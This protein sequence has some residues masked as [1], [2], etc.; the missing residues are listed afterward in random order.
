MK[1]YYTRVLILFHTL[2]WVGNINA[3]SNP[4]DAFIDSVLVHSNDSVYIKQ[5]NNSCIQFYSE[6]QVDSAILY[7]QKAI[8][9][10]KTDNIYIARTYN[11]IANCY[12]LKGAYTIVLNNYLKALSIYEKFNYKP[13]I[14]N[15][16][17]NIGNTYNKNGYQKEAL[18]YHNKALQMRLKMLDSINIALSYNNIANVYHSQ[19]SYTNAIQYHHKALKLKEILGDTV[20]TIIS[21]NNLGGLYADIGESK[22]AI[23]LLSR[24]NNLIQIIKGNKE[25]YGINYVNLCKAYYIDDD[26]A[27][28]K[29]WGLEAIKC[30]NEFNDF[31][32]KM[33]AYNLL[34]LTYK[35]LKDN[36]NALYYL[37]EYVFLK[38]SIFNSEN[39]KRLITEQLEYRYNK[40]AE[41]AKEEEIKRN[42]KVKAD[43][44]K[45]KQIFLF[46]VIILV[47]TVIFALFIYRGYLQKQKSNRF[48]TEQNNL[49]KE[50]QKEIIDSINYAK[51]IQTAILPEMDVFVKSFSDAFALYMPKDIVSGDLYWFAELTT[52]TKNPIHLKVIAVA[53]CTG[54]G[55]PGAF[56]SMLSVQLLNESVKNPN[57]NSPAEL[58][59]YMNRRVIT[60]LR[61][62]NT[63]QI[64]DGLDIAV[65]ALE[66]SNN[67]LYYS[68]ANRP[69]WILRGGIITEYKPTKAAIGGAT[70]I[71]QNFESTTIAL[72]KGDR[73][74]L[75]TDG[76]TD[77]FGG[78]NNKKFTKARLKA[79]IEKNANL[80]FEQ[81][82]VILKDELTRWQGTEEQTDDILIVGY[83]V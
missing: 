68:G 13:G 74:I 42:E 17:N 45:Q 21:L 53:D 41:L 16:Y 54:H 10:C 24:A 8:D 15:I 34:G 26:Y 48:I 35:K 33:D 59:E 70:A 80:S 30:A 63:M 69:L 77:Q 66:S 65:C 23:D 1:S 9:A 55:V 27:N 71:N 3:Q 43:K 44:E 73:V 49:I 81:L 83:T 25:D 2:F 32:T 29:K 82:Q 46:L 12:A 36:E 78:T 31:E 22:R 61:K 72:N 18:V 57:I 11:I 51:R 60:D 14:A 38:D 50:K 28:A 7:C 40:K 64:N 76:I 39:A 56:M 52:T 79:L 37:E 19:K 62:N 4:I 75:F 58:L 47:A 5:I 20:G 67:N 6:G